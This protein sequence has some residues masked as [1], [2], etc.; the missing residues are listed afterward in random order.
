MNT[1]RALSSLFALGLALSMP[2]MASAQTTVAVSATQP[3]RTM[4]NPIKVQ[5]CSPSQNSAVV[6]GFAPAFY[7]VGM[8]AYWGWP[9]VYGPSYY[10][11]PYAT[12]NPSLAIDYHNNTQVTMS[13]IE[14]GLI[15]RGDLVAEV[16]DK[17]TFSPGAEIKHE[18]GL[19]PNV[20]PLH[21]GIVQCVP[22]KITF[23]DGTKWKN[24]NLP[25]MKRAIY[26]HP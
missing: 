25:A 20:F 3:Y 26:Q 21:T 11:Y 2:V 17:G 24:P 13:D 1:A 16:R 10:S 6:G 8:G 5:T 23:A 14:F 19:S 15:A 12:S 9:S 18:F 4:P 22:L 7:P